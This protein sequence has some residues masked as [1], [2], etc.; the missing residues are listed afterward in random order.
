MPKV[1]S[2]PR[3]LRQ[4]VEAPSLDEPRRDASAEPALRQAAR[5]IRF[6]WQADAQTRF[7]DVSPELA[8]AV[9]AM[10]GRHRRADLG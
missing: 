3:T 5:P 8:Q 1:G 4:A 6:V 7:T 10:A 2:R 9:G